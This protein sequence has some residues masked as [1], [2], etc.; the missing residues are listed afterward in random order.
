M[1]KDFE[2]L[3]LYLC[4]VAFILQIDIILLLIE[5]VLLKKTQ[6]EKQ[7]KWGH[8]DEENAPCGPLCYRSV[9]VGFC[10][11]MISLG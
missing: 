11:I 8:V 5:V 7:P 1:L 3:W 9:C 2:F 4:S 6:A 10:T